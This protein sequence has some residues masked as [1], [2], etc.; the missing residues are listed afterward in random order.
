MHDLSIPCRSSIIPALNKQGAASGDDEPGTGEQ[1]NGHAD[2]PL[3][4]AAASERGQGD[5]SATQSDDDEGDS[6]DAS[7]A[8]ASPGAEAA[9]EQL[10]SSFLE[11][12]KYIPLRLS[13][14]ER[15][16]LR[17]LEAALVVSDYTDKVR[18]YTEH[19]GLW[20]SEVATCCMEPVWSQ[21]NVI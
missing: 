21:F 17:L 20:S 6:E 4:Q 13:H 16:L 7:M 2:G 3:H 8:S 14:D 18:F 12:A 15:R 11:R 5:A 19:K 1:A 9:A 10:R